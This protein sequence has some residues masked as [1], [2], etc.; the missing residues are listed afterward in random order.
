MSG[1]PKILQGI[2]DPVYFG[3][4][5][6]IFKASYTARM[7][8]LQ[9]VSE[10]QHRLEVIA[11]SILSRPIRELRIAQQKFEQGQL[12]IESF[13]SLLTSFRISTPPPL[14]VALSDYCKPLLSAA[15]NWRSR[16][17]LSSAAGLF[18]DGAGRIGQSSVEHNLIKLLDEL[19]LLKRALK[20]QTTLDKFGM[21]PTEPIRLSL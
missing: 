16:R 20:E 14:P 12:S 19:V 5:R 17:S 18:Y 2:E 7:Q 3:A 4:N 1:Q 15:P 13:W 11:P 9:Q 21:C 6:A 8:A 10:I